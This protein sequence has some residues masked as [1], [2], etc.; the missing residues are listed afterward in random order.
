MTEKGVGIKEDIELEQH[1]LGIKREI[2]DVARERDP[3][4]I[5]GLIGNVRKILQEEK[6]RGKNFLAGAKKISEI[7]E[8]LHGSEY[9]VDG[10][11]AYLPRRGEGIFIGDIH[12]DSEAIISI[13]EQTGFIEDMESGS[14][15]KVLVFEGDCIN[16]GK[17]SIGAL[18]LVL[19]LKEKYP[20]NVVLIRG[21]HEDR[22]Q[23]IVENFRKKDCL[24]KSIG[25]EVYPG[26]KYEDSK[27]RIELLSEYNE[28]FEELPGIVF[29]ANGIMAVHGGIPNEGVNSLQQLNDERKLR[30]MRWNDP[31]FKSKNIVPN[32]DRDPEGE[33]DFMEFGEESFVEF[34][35]QVGA[36]V[37]IR[38]HDI[39][40]NG[41]KI[42]FNGKLVTIF[43]TGG[44]KSKSVYYKY[45]NGIK[46]PKIAVVDL[47][48]DKEEWGESDFRKIEYI[49]PNL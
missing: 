30:Q 37:M 4:K 41:A 19:K 47:E 17:D 25:E 35:N 2:Y 16:R 26:D 29:T 31:G 11:V 38:S 21:N 7:E 42:I 18:G 49:K 14:K 28:L 34:M 36:Q 40:E 13:I 5:E 20:R 33:D 8:G 45:K 10:N 44:N 24:F 15:E 9:F 23:I 27:K 3:E 48:E 12:G 32:K 1:I 6:E 22:D 39:E 46:T 43:S